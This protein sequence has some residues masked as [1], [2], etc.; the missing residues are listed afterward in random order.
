MISPAAISP[1]QRTGAALASADL[2]RFDA[3]RLMGDSIADTCDGDFA[4]YPGIPTR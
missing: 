4:T 3:C 2:P 1:R